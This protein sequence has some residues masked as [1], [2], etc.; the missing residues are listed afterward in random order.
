MTDADTI[1]IFH[2]PQSRS[3]GALTLLEELGA[4]YRLHVLNMKAGE[5]R[6]PEYLAV[7]PLGKVPAILHRGA[8]V[9][10]QVAIFIY[11][12]DLFPNAALAP[13]IGDVRRGPYLRWLVYYASCYEP[14][15]VDRA[16]QREPAP[17][18]TSPYGT[19]DT[20]LESVV[21]QIRERPFLLGETISAADILWGNAL[22]WGVMFKL[23][24]EEK[25][26]ADYVARIVQRPAAIKVATMDSELAAEHQKALG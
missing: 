17:Q 9:T 13:A 18:A 24:P 19:F 5:Q 6:R 3:S 16:M 2:S 20:M 23:V 8:L 12:A 14:A 11:L 10:E 26:I 1:T 25:A 21:S 22:N 7:N 15:L 4:P